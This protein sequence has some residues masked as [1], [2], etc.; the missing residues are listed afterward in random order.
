LRPATVRPLAA[1]SSRQVT[2]RLWALANRVL[3]RSEATRRGSPRGTPPALRV[4]RRAS[5]AISAFSGSLRF[6]FCCPRLA[7]RPS[8]ERARLGSRP[9]SA[10]K[11]RRW[12]RVGLAQPTGW[13]WS[14][15][16]RHG[17]PVAPKAS[18]ARVPLAGPCPGAGLLGC[19][20]SG[21]LATRQPPVRTR[22]RR[23]RGPR[24]TGPLGPPLDRRSTAGAGPG[25]PGGAPIIRTLPAAL[26][27][28]GRRSWQCPRASSHDGCRVRRAERTI[29]SSVARLRSHYLLWLLAK[30]GY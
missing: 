12:C 10:T 4:A 22:S 29:S 14:R 15:L 2:P 1:E 23:W 25:G 5:P 8:L 13:L 27:P 3:K 9:A 26:L 30:G 28:A 24:R 16:S 17:R 7:V 18:V 6:G 21:R 20:P 11:L 19:G